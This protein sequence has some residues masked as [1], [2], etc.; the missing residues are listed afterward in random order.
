MDI[1]WN[2]NT[3]SNSPLV[4]TGGSITVFST[5][6]PSHVALGKDPVIVCHRSTSS[7]EAGG[8]NSA[9]NRSSM[10]SGAIAGLS[11]AV[12]LVGISLLAVFALLL[13]RRLKGNAAD[14]HKDVELTERVHS[15]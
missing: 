1:G 13:L 3:Y 9:N 14:S 7:A 6:V 10:S 12:I 15:E 4:Y 8:S 2:G 5:A 11:F